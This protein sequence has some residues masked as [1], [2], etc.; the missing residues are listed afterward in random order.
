MKRISIG[1]WAYAIGPYADHPV[2]FDEVVRRLAG[3]GFDGIDLGGF[4]PHPNPDTL[5]TKA[6]R[7]EVR[8]RVADAGLAFSGLAADLWSQQLINAED[9]GRA[10]LECFRKNAQFAEDLG[11]DCVRVDTVQPP[12]IF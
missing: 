7:D 10:Y 4:A 9:E 6:Q 2:P 8:K 5:A 11:I 1:T 12:T 3:L